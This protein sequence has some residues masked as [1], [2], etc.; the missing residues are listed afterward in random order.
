MATILEIAFGLALGDLLK[1]LI[2]HGRARAKRRIE[3]ERQIVRLRN[4]AGTVE[5]TEMREQIYGYLKTMPRDEALIEQVKSRITKI[6]EQEN[7][8]QRRSSR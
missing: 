8:P 3:L 6:K 1:E 2:A 4:R 7:E 5:S